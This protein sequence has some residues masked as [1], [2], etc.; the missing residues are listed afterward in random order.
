MKES[1]GRTERA[2]QR[3]QQPVRSDTTIHEWP[4]AGLVLTHGPADPEASVRVE[5]TAEFIREAT[6]HD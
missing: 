3:E 6:S 5:S 2:R 1:P 4:E